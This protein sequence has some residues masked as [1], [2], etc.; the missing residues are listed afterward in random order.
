MSTRVGADGEVNSCGVGVAVVEGGTAGAG[1]DGTGMRSAMLGTA[2][3]RAGAGAATDGAA[4]A[5]GMGGGAAGAIK[6]TEIMPRPLTAGRTMSAVAV[7][8]PTQGQRTFRR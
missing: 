7:L 1:R 3:G 6:S 4:V 5:V 8:C 2:T